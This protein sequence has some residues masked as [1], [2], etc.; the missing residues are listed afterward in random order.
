MTKN[1][2]MEMAQRCG[3]YKNHFVQAC[4]KHSSGAWVGVEDELQDFANTILERAA[5]E[6]STYGVIQDMGGADAAEIVRS[7]KIPTN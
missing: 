5:V 4:T 7:L 6:L 3:F 2:L 1:E